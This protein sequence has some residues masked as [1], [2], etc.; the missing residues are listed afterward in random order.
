M[1]SFQRTVILAYRNKELSLVLPVDGTH[2]HDIVQYGD[3]LVAATNRSRAPT[4]LIMIAQSSRPSSASQI[5]WLSK[6]KGHLV[7]LFRPLQTHRGDMDPQWTRPYHSTR[8]RPAR[9]YY[10]AMQCSCAVTYA[11]SYSPR[12]CHRTMHHAPVLMQCFPPCRLDR[13]RIEVKCRYSLAAV[14][15]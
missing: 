5:A 7:S 1:I 4:Q 9:V 2:A 12:S 13:I 11:L 15:R 14:S 8:P 10:K 3:H 6:K